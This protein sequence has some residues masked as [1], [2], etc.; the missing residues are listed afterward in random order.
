M[1]KY[2]K[3]MRSLLKGFIFAGLMSSATSHAAPPAQE[4]LFLVAPVKPIMMFNMSKDHQLFFKLY[5]DYSDITGDG[6]IDTTYQNSFD[7]YGYFDSDK[8]YVYD[9][10]NGRFSPNATLAVNHYCQ[11]VTDTTKYWS[12]NFL[13]WA[14][15]TRMDAIRKILYGGYRSTDTNTLTVLERAFLPNDAHSFAKWYGGSDLRRLT[16]YDDNAAAVDARDRGLTLCNTSE[17]NVRNT[18]SQN[19]TGANDRPVIRLARGNYSLWASNERWQCRWGINSNGNVPASSGIDAYSNSPNSNSL[20]V[21]TNLSGQVQIGANSNQVNWISGNDFNGLSVGGSINIDGTNYTINSLNSSTQLNVNTNIDPPLTGTVSVTSNSDLVNLVTGSFSGLAVNNVINIEGSNRTILAINSPSQIQVDHTY[22]LATGDVLITSGSNQVNFVGG[23]GTNFANLNN[24]DSVTIDGQVR[25]ITAKNSNTQIVVDHTYPQASVSGQVTISSNSNVINYSSGTNFANLT[26]GS[27]ITINGVVRTV[28]TKNNNS[29]IVVNTTYPTFSGTVNLTAGSNVVTYSSGRDFQDYA[30][31]DTIRIN[32]TNR[33]ITGKISNTQITV[34]TTYAST[35]SN[36]NYTVASIVRDYSASVSGVQTTVAYSSVVSRNVSF[37][38]TKSPRTANY[39]ASYITPEA[40]AEL[41]ARVVACSSSALSSDYCRPY[42]PTSGAYAGQTIY[43]PIGLLQEYANKVNFGLM[44]GSYRNNKSGGVLRKLVGPIDVKD[45]IASDTVA[46]KNIAAQTDEIGDDGIFKVPSGSNNSIIKSLD[47]LRVYGYNFNDGTYNDSRPGGDNCDWA[48]SFFNDELSGGG[49]GRCS[50]WGNPQAEIFL[51]SLRYLAGKSASTFSVDD[52]T[53]ISGLNRVSTWVDPISSGTSGNKCAALNVL[54]FNASTTSYDNDSLAV[55]AD[56]SFTA[57][58]IK[59][60]TSKIGALEGVDSVSGTPQFFVGRNGTDNNQLCTPKDINSTTGGLGNAD[61]VCSE[62]PRLEGGYNIAGLAYLARKNGVGTDREKVKTHGVVLAPAIPSISIPVPGDATKTVT[63]LPACR[64]TTPNPDAN[65]AIVDFKVVSGPTLSGGKYTGTLYVNWEDSEQG[66][67]YDQDMWGV[68]NYEVTNTSVIVRTQ[69][70]AQ[71]T[72]DSMGFGYV[73]SGT[74]NDGFHVHSGV[75]TFVH[76][77]SGC[78]GTACRCRQ[79]GDGSNDASHNAC[80]AAIAVQTQKSFVVG[81]STARQ[82]KNPLWYAAKW[83]GYTK[84]SSTDTEIL[85]TDPEVETAA[86]LRTYFYATNPTVLQT[87]LKKLFDNIAGSVGS[88]STVA[89]NS[90]SSQGETHVYQAR[91]D[92]EDWSG[93]VLD[94]GLTPTGVSATP[95]WDTHDT[96]SR[97]GGFL[98]GRKVYTY[99]GTTPS[100]VELTDANLYLADLTVVDNAVPDLTRSLKLGSEADYDYAI[101]RI[102]WLRGDSTEETS[103][104]FRKRTHLLGDIINSDPGYAGAGSQRHNN[105]PNASAFGASSY[106]TYVAA[107]KARKKMV[108]VGANDGMLHAFDAA[109]GRELFAYIP[110]GVYKKL[111]ALMDINYSHQYTVDGPV[112]VSDYYRKDGTWGTIVAGTLGSGGRGAYALDVTDVLEGTTSAPTVIF[113]ISDDDTTT[114]QPNAT[115]KNDIGYSGS[116]VLVLPVNAPAADGGGRWMAIFSNGTDSAS[117]QAK[118]IAIDVNDPTKFVSVNTGVSANGLSPA[119][120]LLGGQNLVV[121]AYAGDILGN[122]W[123]FDLSN[124][125]YTLWG[126]AFGAGNPLINVVDASGNPQPITA[127]PTLGLNTLKPV[128]TTPSVM[129][130]FATGKYSEVADLT[131][132]SIQSIYAIADTG[133]TISIDEFNRTTLLHEKWISVESSSGRTVLNDK[134]SEVT[135]TAPA[136]DWDNKNGWFMDLVVKSGPTLTVGTPY[137]ER[138][139]NKPLL[140]SDRLIIN[141]FIPSA[142]QCD[143]GGSGWLMEL[144]GV[145]D[146][147]VDHSVLDELANTQLSRPIISDLVPF[148]AGDNILILGSNLGGKKEENLD[149]NSTITTIEGEAAGGTRGRMSW[150]QV[151]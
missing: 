64:N 88:A 19:A 35:Q 96:M 84:D 104:L 132:T 99:D 9:S 101:R 106:L 3:K 110:R 75:N 100:V 79:N 13:N 85:A 98:T 150:R 92:S 149:V 131:D 30:V 40:N 24:G 148:Q 147:F 50:N 123:K 6:N 21:T 121:A 91:F 69:V 128:G 83:G 52:S 25:T 31:G 56:I 11:A 67:D 33:L 145:G 133:S 29:Q 4:P 63:I 112:Y 46:V 48:L 59:T 77:G 130:Y 1:N 36:R 117:D 10:A 146:K 2:M 126:S 12:G 20:D 70:M 60:E 55:A 66:G 140:I 26:S 38:A 49:V 73:I 54:Q 127:E 134:T 17:P 90:T 122:M 115:L 22:P 111:S 139:L 97:S 18:Y 23:S 78:T 68:M 120:F 27:S 8:C 72:G 114:A 103:L 86:N 51:E 41:I 5:D 113:D 136:V 28:N 89:A 116:K 44:T 129:V 107:K 42:K 151:K 144:V 65:C 71:S 142:N 81:S 61:G 34:N 32:S 141:T 137:G 39:S 45:P 94:F 118:L 37:T 138:G 58:G 125:D 109:D 93:Q 80:Q 62:A 47:L 53:F 119:A 102:K 16:P 95:A 76:P 7:Y 15:M 124:P 135:N 105:L 143:Y 82:L 43:K 87:A 14:T 108:F 74:T 57:A